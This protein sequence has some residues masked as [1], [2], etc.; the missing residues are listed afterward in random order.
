MNA[1]NRKLF[2]DRSSRQKL[3]QMGGI[4]ASSS[5]LMGEAQRFAEGGVVKPEGEPVAIV[6]GRA[7]YVSEDE[8]NI[9]DD[10]G[11]IVT[12]P[13]VMQAV[14]AQAMPAPSEGQSTGASTE[15]ETAL[16]NARALLDPEALDRIDAS[17][18][19]FQVPATEREPIIPPIPN[20]GILGT[21]GALTVAND[22]ERKAILYPDRENNNRAAGFKYEPPITAEMEQELEVLERQRAS[23]DVASGIGSFARKTNDSIKGILNHTI[24]QTNDNIRAGVDLV[25]DTAADLA[26]GA[27][28]VTGGGGVS[29]TMFDLSNSIKNATDRATAEGDYIPRFQGRDRPPSQ[30]ELLAEERRQIS[31]DS[32]R[33][34]AAGDASLFA[35]GS[36]PEQ[37]QDLSPSIIQ[38]R[39]MPSPNIE[40]SGGMPIDLSGTE[41]LMASTPIFNTPS[42][43]SIVNRSSP[44]GPS[45]VR[46]NSEGI[47]APIAE[48][49][50]AV[51]EERMAAAAAGLTNENVT[52][53]RFPGEEARIKAQD[54]ELSTIRN[55][56]LSKNERTQMGMPE[57][58]RIVEEATGPSTLEAPPA[59]ETTTLGPAA[60]ETPTSDITADLEKI[61]AAPNNGPADASRKFANRVLGNPDLDAKGSAKAYEKRAQ[62][63]LG[64]EDKETSKEMWNN[65][66]MI[67]FAIA[68]GESPNALSNIANGLLAGT[69]MMKE[70]RTSAAAAEA[71]LTKTALAEANEDRRLDA[72][73]RSSERRSASGGGGSFSTQD[74]MYKSIYDNA[75]ASQRVAIEDGTITL[76]EADAEAS[77][78]ARAGAPTSQLSAPSIPKKPKKDPSIFEG[79]SQEE[80]SALYETNYTRDPSKGRALRARIEEGGFNTAGLSR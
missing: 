77:A 42:S 20:R 53:D 22:E 1:Q 41:E 27:G 44:R 35:E 51:L 69:K 24:G 5:D 61:V 68:A 14:M 67:G 7:F 8:Q 48:D 12:D 56:Q 46:I 33:A 66:A 45:S 34:I 79:M 71:E 60:T 26:L 37:L 13:M 9:V 63:M 70:D 28:Y 3:S 73:L 80:V 62:E 30:A 74:R 75:M 39:N 55:R 64:I 49:E 36:V 6:A 76:V 11:E 78:L 52:A 59:I 32:N 25:G 23:R 10:Q 50:S 2:V 16:A 18:D 72:R 54:D 65:M 17:G 57:P 43:D 40:N 4:M 58:D 38:A 21:I 29:K 47:P 31:A 19:F 15:R